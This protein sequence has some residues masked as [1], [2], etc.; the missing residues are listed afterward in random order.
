MT[1]DIQHLF[2][3]GG[4][5]VFYKQISILYSLKNNNLLDKVK[6]ITGYS[7]GAITGILYCL[8]ICE[9]DFFR[10]LE[11]INILNIKDYLSCIVLQKNLINIFIN[12]LLYPF[13]EFKHISMDISLIDFYKIT[14]IELKIDCYRKSIE[15][16]ES[17]DCYFSYIN[18]PTLKL[19]DVVALTISQDVSFINLKK[20]TYENYTYQDTPFKLIYISSLLKNYDND[21]ILY[22]GIIQ[23]DALLNLPSE[24]PYKFFTNF[25]FYKRNYTNNICVNNILDTI[26]TNKMVK[27]KI[28]KS[29]NVNG[30]N[31]IEINYKNLI[32]EARESL[33]L[34]LDNHH[35]KELF[36]IL[37]KE[38]KNYNNIKSNNNEHDIVNKKI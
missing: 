8:N 2:C 18:H 32:V 11:D 21:S 25:I 38:Y 35:R 27:H 30:L 1:R 6:T 16:N 4:Y 20:I 22:L 17:E 23:Q 5:S 10:I 29:F 14:G 36:N 37:N 33:L 24:D 15:T 19:K 26:L 7:S 9:S 12:R 13:F 31:L 3:E 34:L 28:L